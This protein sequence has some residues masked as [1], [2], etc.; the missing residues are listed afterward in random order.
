MLVILEW[1][2]RTNFISLNY[3]P[4]L[5][6]SIAVELLNSLFYGS[7]LRFFRR[8]S[9]DRVLAVLGWQVSTHLAF[10]NSLPLLWIAVKLFYSPFWFPVLWFSKNKTAN[11]VR[12]VLVMEL[13]EK[14]RRREKRRKSQTRTWCVRC[15]INTKWVFSELWSFWLMHIFRFFSELDGFSLRV[16][17]WLED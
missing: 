11:E 16:D 9:V 12:V 2:V 13:E 8:K 1:L 6:F 17:L 4:F 3:S 7:V 15:Y 5:T 14:K 10:S